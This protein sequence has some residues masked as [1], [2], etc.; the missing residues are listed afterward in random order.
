[1]GDQY[2][3]KVLIPSAVRGDYAIGLRALARFSK[4]IIALVIPLFP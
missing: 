2:T 3:T 4:K 1:M